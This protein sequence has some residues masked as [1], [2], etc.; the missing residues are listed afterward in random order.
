MNIRAKDLTKEAPASPKLRVGGYAVLARLADKARAEFLGG[1]IG[2]YRTNGP[3]DRRLLDWKGVS[4]DEI[5]RVIVNGGNNEAVA[6]YLS[7]HGILKTPEEITAWSDAMDKRNPYEEPELREIYAAE[8]NK[9]GL[10]PANTP[11]FDF[12]EADDRH[13]FGTPPAQPRAPAN[14][15]WR[16]GP[17]CLSCPLRQP[18]SLSLS[19][20]GPEQMPFYEI[21]TSADL[22]RIFSWLHRAV[23][24][25]RHRCAQRSRYPS[26]RLPRR[27]RSGRHPSTRP[28]PRWEDGWQ[29]GFLRL[30]PSQ[31]RRD[32]LPERS[33]F[34]SVPHFFRFDPPPGSGWQAGVRGQI[35]ERA[36]SGSA[37]RLWP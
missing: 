9:L 2:V 3:L 24:L 17:F 23:E 34:R 7:A 25:A 10:D 30:A 22:H 33:F 6:A 16:S 14:R 13:T 29:M 18:L 4:Y 11:S 37:H 28:I 15:G 5:K 8:V 27:H 31:T 12:L 32:H 20:L 35:P 21:I 1:K 26:G 36:S 19:P